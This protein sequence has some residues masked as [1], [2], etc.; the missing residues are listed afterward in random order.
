M[1]SHIWD[2]P[3]AGAQLSQQL[4]GAQRSNNVSVG[5]TSITPINSMLAQKAKPHPG[6]DVFLCFTLP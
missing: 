2:S 6:G 5:N 4:P 3:G 1:Q